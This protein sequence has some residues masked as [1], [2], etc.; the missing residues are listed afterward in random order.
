MCSYQWLVTDAENIGKLLNNHIKSIQFHLIECLLE[1]GPLIG[2][3]F[4]L[5]DSSYN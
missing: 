4:I 1:C 3:Y 2:E 5:W